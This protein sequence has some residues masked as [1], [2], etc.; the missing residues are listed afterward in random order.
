MY[1]PP[2]WAGVVVTLTAEVVAI[3]VAAIITTRRK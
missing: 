2:F 1:I 3:I